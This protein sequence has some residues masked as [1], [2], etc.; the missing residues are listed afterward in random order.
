MGTVRPARPLSSH[1]NCLSGLVVV[2]A[3]VAVQ[4][5]RFCGRPFVFYTPPSLVCHPC[6]RHGLGRPASSTA[7]AAAA[8]SGPGCPRRGAQEPAGSDRLGS[9]AGYASPAR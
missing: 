7:A 5:A 9:V 2:V 4:L 6:W 3:V 1:L 8:D